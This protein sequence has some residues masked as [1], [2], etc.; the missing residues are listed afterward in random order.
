MSWIVERIPNSTG[1]LRGLIEEI[2]EDGEFQL[3]FVSSGFLFFR[4]ERNPSFDER[5]AATEP[6]PI[7][8][9]KIRPPQRRTPALDPSI[10]SARERNADD[11]IPQ[12]DAPAPR[13]G[14]SDPFG[15]D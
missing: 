9:P 12:E 14:G 5:P 8:V 10:L 1:D 2:E 4:G 6:A 3:K 7:L 13:G 15:L 11:I